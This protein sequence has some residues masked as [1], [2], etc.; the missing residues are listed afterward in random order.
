MLVVFVTPYFT[1]GAR[2]F[3]GKVADHPGIRLAVV[4]ME[5]TTVLP[6]ELRSRIVRALKV[7]NTMRAADLVDAARRI[8]QELGP[9]Q[10]M[11]APTE[12]VQESVAEARE[13]LGIP[14]LPLATALNFRDKD[15]MKDL[16]R[17]AG[18]PVARHR[19]V[20]NLEEARAFA[21]LVGLPVVVKPPAGAAS[22][23]TFRAEDDASLAAAF[24][25]ASRVAG[26]VALLEEFVTGQEHSFDAFIKDGRVLFCS[27]SDYL[28]TPLDAMRNRWIQWCVL[29]HR[30]EVAPDIAAMGQKMLNV[31]GL[32]SGVCH[33]EWFRRKDGSLVISECAARPGGAMLPTLISRAH[34]VDYVGAWVRL[35]TA[36]TF[37]PFPPRKYAA[38]AAFLR[39]QGHGRVRAVRGL[40]RVWKDLGGLVTDTRL[41][42]VG[43][44]ASR[45]Y[46]GEGVVCVR[47]PET[48]VVE[49]ALQHIIS[50]VRVELG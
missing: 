28:P 2:Q 46:E 49:Q 19:L 47:H 27:T 45:S 25:G 33:A 29:L 3:L 34:D 40:D 43:Q 22:Q 8:A 35:M 37:E 44:E 23:D 13:A 15:R 16:L 50:V 39:G 6:A 12:Q 36:G 10:R 24:S 20:H 1:D 41:P 48:R 42:S 38:G 32:E 4:A 11:L 9:I 14:G 18:V 7:E 21:A 5:D 30:D 31:L 17:K 26:G